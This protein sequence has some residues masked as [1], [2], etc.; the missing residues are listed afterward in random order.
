MRRGDFQRLGWQVENGYYIDAMN[1][2]SESMDRPIT[3]SIFSDSGRS[4]LGEILTRPG[5]EYVQTRGDVIDL[6]AMSRAS[7]IITT[8]KSTFGYWAAF[9]SSAD[10]ILHPDHTH[11]KI[12]G[13]GR[14]EGTVDCYHQRHG[15]IYRA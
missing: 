13:D 11:G 14:F 4:E 3:F 9:L 8:L 6:W 10:I 15:R 7:T 12:V 2:L 1:R 5:T